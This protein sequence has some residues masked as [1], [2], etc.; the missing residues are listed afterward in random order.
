MKSE[1]NELL[2]ITVGSLK[3]LRNRTL[4]F[5]NNNRISLIVLRK[6]LYFNV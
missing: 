1:G 6:S 4:Q 3:T 5:F 2:S